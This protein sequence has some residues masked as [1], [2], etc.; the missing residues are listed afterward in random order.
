MA[1][2]VG[3]A[4]SGSHNALDGLLLSRGCSLGNPNAF[5]VNV[6]KFWAGPL[7]RGDGQIPSHKSFVW[8]MALVMQ[9]TEDRAGL[10]SM[11]GRSVAA[12][13]YLS[14]FFP[15]SPLIM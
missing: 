9:C 14:G 6:P 3:A 1:L 12:S 2:T 4:R 5:L 11:I 7:F 13:T 15:V 10:S 8:I